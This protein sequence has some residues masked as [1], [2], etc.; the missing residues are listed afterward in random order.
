MDSPPEN[1]VAQISVDI[2]M[3]VIRAGAGDDIHDTADALP[4]SGAYPL[5]M[6]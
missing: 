2:A 1:S 6:I 3:K 4:Y 5:V